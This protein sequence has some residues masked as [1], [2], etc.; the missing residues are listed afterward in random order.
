MKKIKFISNY[1]IAIF[2]LYFPSLVGAQGLIDGNKIDIAAKTSNFSSTVGFS[3][4]SIGAVVAT[5]LKTALS[6]LALLFLVLTVMAGFQWMNAGGNEEVV[7]KAQS[8]FKN[9]I[10]GLVIVL[11]AYAITYFIFN[12]LPF[13]MGGSP[14]A[15]PG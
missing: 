14:T 2:A 11:A 9:A 3:E 5:L 4:A 1:L 10:I 6:I 12:N 13:S 15:I 7:K 8:S